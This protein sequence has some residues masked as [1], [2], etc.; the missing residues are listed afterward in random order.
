MAPRTSRASPAPADVGGASLPRVLP[1]TAHRPH[2]RACAPRPSPPAT[3]PSR[4]SWGTR[5]PAPL[6]FTALGPTAAPPRPKG[7]K[8]SDSRSARRRSRGRGGWAVKVGKA[9]EAS[10]SVQPAKLGHSATEHRASSIQRRLPSC[11]SRSG[12]PGSRL[13]MRQP[14]VTGVSA[15]AGQLL[16]TEGNPL[17]V[18]AEPE[19]GKRGRE[20]SVLRREA[21]AQRRSFRAAL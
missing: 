17:H 6:G 21:A 9:C 1:P 7:A 16:S 4:P 15:P 8:P 20:L 2:Q 18:A 14:G 13:R 19:K 10:G 5:P 11:I 3:H 12:A